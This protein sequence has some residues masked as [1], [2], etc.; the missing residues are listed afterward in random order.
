MEST[1]FDERDLEDLG[2]VHDLIKEHGHLQK[3]ARRLWKEAIKWPWPLSLRL[4]R[5]AERLE[6]EFRTRAEEFRVSLDWLD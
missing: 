2:R 1:G 4:V 6:K 5:K 3:E